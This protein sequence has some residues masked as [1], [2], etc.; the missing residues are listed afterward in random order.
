[1]ESLKLQLMTISDPA[2]VTYGSYFSRAR[3]SE[4]LKNSSDR[5]CGKI[6][7][8][9]SM[10]QVFE[11]AHYKHDTTGG[12]L[13]LHITVGQAER[14]LRSKF[15]RYQHKSSTQILI[16][17]DS[18]TLPLNLAGHVSFVYPITEFPTSRRLTSGPFI[19]FV[20]TREADYVRNAGIN[21]TDMIDL[22]CNTRIVKT[23]HIQR[24]LADQ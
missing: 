13:H 9:L 5:S 15:L 4:S 24:L 18:Y 11:D 7:E 22:R 1:M 20:E 6:K 19:S 3:V 14:L 21:S 8:W 23:F 16:R 2:H 12:V 10:H 17:A